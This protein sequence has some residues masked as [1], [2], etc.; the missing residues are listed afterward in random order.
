MVIKTRL[1][2]TGNSMRCRQLLTHTDKESFIGLFNE[3]QIKGGMK[4]LNRDLLS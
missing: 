1:R 2:N 4:K 3:W